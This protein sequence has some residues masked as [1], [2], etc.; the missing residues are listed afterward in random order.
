[1]SKEQEHIIFERKSHMNSNYMKRCSN[2]IVIKEKHTK[3]KF[4]LSFAKAVKTFQ[5]AIHSRSGWSAVKWTLIQSSRKY[6]GKHA[7]KLK[8]CGFLITSFNTIFIHSANA[9]WASTTYYARACL[10]PIKKGFFSFWI[11]FYF[12]VLLP[13]WETPA[14]YRTE[15][16]RVE[17]LAFFLMFPGKLSIFQ[18]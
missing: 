17:I 8:K 9:C 12:F 10:L 7:I 4:Q 2:L 1:M 14:Q 3:M 6:K 16:V 15:V 11:P 5:C 13:W 18:Y